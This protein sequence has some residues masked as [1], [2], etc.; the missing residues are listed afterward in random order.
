MNTLQLYPNP[1]KARLMLNWT[2]EL[3][4]YCAKITD[5]T[6]IQYFRLIFLNNQLAIPNLSPGYYFIK[7]S[8]NETQQTVPFIIE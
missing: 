1:I 5:L 7:L 2:L 3:Y 6:G 8:N 4:F